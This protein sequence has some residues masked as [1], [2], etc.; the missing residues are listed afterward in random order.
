MR[1]NHSFDPK[2]DELMYNL[3]NKYGDEMFEATGIGESQLDINE[4]SKAFFNEAEVTADV[5]VDANANVSQK[6]GITYD[7]EFPKPLAKLN[8]LF[9]L[10]KQ[11]SKN[12]GDELAG[13]IIEAHIS[14]DF[15]I[16]DDSSVQKPYCMNFSAYDIALEGLSNI[17]KGLH[18]RPPKSL[19]TF[20]EQ[21]KQFLVV[22]AN[23]ILGASGTS[24]IFIVSSLY[25]QKIMKTGYDGHIRVTNPEN[26]NI[27]EIKTYV[28]EAICHFVYYLN[29]PY[30]SGQTIF[31]NV[32]VFDDVFLSNLCPDYR[33]FDVEA[34][35]EVVKMVQEIFI[36]VMNEELERTPLTFPVTTACFCVEDGKILDEEFVDFIAEKN[37]KYGFINIYSG[38][39][40]T[41]SSCCRLRS[42]TDNPYMNTFGAG[43]TKIGSVGVVTANLPRAAMKAVVEAEASLDPEMK[44]DLFL[45]EVRNLFDMT[46]A[47]NWARRQL[48]R[49]RTELGANPLYTYGFMDDKKQYATFGLNGINEAVSILGY[50]ILTKS[51]QELVDRLIDNINDWIV[52]AQKQYGC[53]INCE[54]TPSEN[55]AVKLAKKDKLLGYDCGVPLYSNQFIPLTTQANLLDRIKLQARWDS[56]FSGGAICHLSVGQ[57][58]ED[59]KQFADLMRHAMSTGVIYFAVNY[60]INFDGSHTWVGGEVCPKCGHKCTDTYERVVGFLVATKNYNPVR[61]EHDWPKRQRYTTIG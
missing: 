61:R 8:S 59:P 21:M 20:L 47:V 39:S 32:S 40:S 46:C 12:V 7:N 55:S 22:A 42:E 11:L 2:F 58:I 3:R 24:D 19:E 31:S 17:I 38:K 57:R 16:N 36:D 48:V 49:K 44:V 60:T 54:Q 6:T 27:E 13:R 5:S 35:K 1:I 52:L 53:P 4:F 23:S 34:D 25:V 33:L 29:W 9:M 45:S 10:W 41:L 14:G 51:G 50:D 43:S 37:T 15:Y 30:R 18:I 26:I 28:K 56:R